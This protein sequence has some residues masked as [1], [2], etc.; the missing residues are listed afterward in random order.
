MTK[1][2]LVL[3]ITV[4]VT[5]PVIAILDHYEAMS[6][7]KLECTDAVQKEHIRAIFLK[8]VDRG[9]EEQV[10][11]L[12]DIWVKDPA[13]AQ[14]K[15]AQTGADNAV[16]AYVRAHKAALAWNPPECP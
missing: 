1:N 7:I 5:L 4:A 14:P 2:I 6:Q 9:L 15:R 16:N 8:A 11:H 12:F 10:S 13:V 3:I